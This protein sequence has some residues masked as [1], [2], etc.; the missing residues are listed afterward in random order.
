MGLT[1]NTMVLGKLGG[2][3]L[4]PSTVVRLCILLRP[5]INAVWAALVY[6]LAQC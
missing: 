4:E 2:L 5:G 6:I 1:L 3:M